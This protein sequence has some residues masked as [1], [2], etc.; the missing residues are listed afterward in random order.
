MLGDAHQI[1]A[2]PAVDP[3]VRLHALDE[4]Q[5]LGVDGQHRVA[6]PFGGQPP[7]P[8]H[9]AAAPAGGVAGL[10]VRV[11]ADDGRVALVTGRERLEVGDPR[12]LG[13]R[14]GVP[15][16]GLRG[17]VGTVPVEHDLQARPPRVCHDPVQHLE[18]GQAPQVGVDAVVVDAA[19]QGARLE[20]VV[21][22]GDADG[23]VAQGLDLVEH[24]LVV[25][26]PQAVGHPD[27]GL[28]A[29]PV[30]AG[31]PYGL[32]RSVQDLPAA[33]VPV[34]FTGR[35]R[36]GRRG[37]GRRTGRAVARLCRTGRLHTRQR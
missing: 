36:T 13:H 23:V 24:A 9:I 6:G 25:A 33:G 21:A 19:G 29:E 15:E 3:V 14:V 5:Q 2:P 32:P 35:R 11:D 28:E 1:A 10:V 27:V 18:R 22:V 7:V 8:C 31:D 30:D 17:R 4:D 20:D 16:R 34:P 37:T 12:R 26:G